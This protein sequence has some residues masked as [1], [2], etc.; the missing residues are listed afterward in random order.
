MSY[1]HPFFSTLADAV[2]VPERLHGLELPTRKTEDFRF[3]N[4]KPIVE[5]DWAA[6]EPGTASLDSW[7]LAESAGTLLVVRNGVV[8]LDS[9]KLDLPAGVFV[10]PLSSLPDA[11]AAAARDAA[12]TMVD[13]FRDDVFLALNEAAAND[14][15]CIVLQ[16]DA[17][18]EA[19]IQVLYE[20]RG[21]DTFNAPRLIVLAA[22][23]S[24]ATIV[25]DFRG[26]DRVFTNA[27]SH[28]VVSENANVHHVRVQREGTEARHVSRVVARVGKFARY[29]SVHITLGALSSRNDVWVSHD[30]DDGWSRIDGL[31]MVDDTREADTHSVIDNRR[32]RCESHQL[33]KCVVDGRGHA[34][35][36]GKIFVREGAQHTD[37]YQLNRNLLLSPRAKIDTKPQLEIWADDVQCTHGAT[38]GQLDDEQLFYLQSRG[39]A[40]DAALATLTYAFAAEVIDSIEVPSLASELEATAHQRT[41]SREQS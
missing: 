29:D 8:D 23:G 10:G 24:K 3:F 1:T 17:V 41:M 25:E 22:A 38:I 6:G 28:I 12:A 13:G 7:V 14:A 32:L 37:A 19:P 16:S 11:E 34:V 20:G 31:A 2:K 26:D 5:H 4:L 9:S 27:V 39:M 21:D 15:A 30:G 36:N 33:H 35:F 40:P 18:V